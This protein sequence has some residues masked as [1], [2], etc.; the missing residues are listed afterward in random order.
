[1]VKEDEGADIQFTGVSDLDAAE[2]D[3]VQVLSREYYDKIKRQL[4][5]VVNI[6]VHVKRYK[7]EGERNKYSVHV[8]V[9]APMQIFAADHAHFWEL[10]AAIHAAFQDIQNQITHR[11]HTDVTK[12]DRPRI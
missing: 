6:S 7:L 2:Q 9:A 11:L 12:P 5:N 8:K 3:T 10:P 4:Q 1:M